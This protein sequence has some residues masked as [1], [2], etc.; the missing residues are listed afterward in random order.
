MNY[1]FQKN[2]VVTY[3]L[4][5]N[6]ACLYRVY[7]FYY[8]SIE[9]QVNV[10]CINCF[11]T[12]DPSSEDIRLLEVLDARDMIVNQVNRL[13]LA[14]NKYDTNPKLP[15]FFRDQYSNLIVTNSVQEGTLQ[16]DYVFDIV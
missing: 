16:Y 11:L 8:S 4:G 10:P 9:G 3:T 13:N 2:D 5:V 15:I 1:L 7:V 6:Y 12:I 14:I